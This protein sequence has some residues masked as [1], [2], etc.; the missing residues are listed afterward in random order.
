MYGIYIN[1]AQA[2]PTKA[3][4]P[5][6]VSELALFGLEATPVVLGLLAALL[7]ELGVVE[8]EMEPEPEPEDDEEDE[9]EE[10]EDDDEEP[11]E[12]EELEPPI[13]I[14]GACAAAALKASRVLPVLGAGL[15]D[16][17]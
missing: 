8:L 5:N 12:E 1:N 9:D 10:D 16:N 7:A 15:W 14:I 3:V 11:E 4:H 2:T 13:I 17:Y 6:A